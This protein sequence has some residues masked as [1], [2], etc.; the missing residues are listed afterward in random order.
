MPQ[1]PHD[2][3]Y[4]APGPYPPIMVRERNTDYARVIY[5][6]F[7]GRDSELTAITQYLY[8]HFAANNMEVA[9]LLENIAMVEMHHLEMLGQVIV[10]LGGDPRYWGSGLSY[11]NGSYVNYETDLCRALQANLPGEQ[12]AQQTYQN[13]A[14]QIQDPYVRE[15]LLRIAR[16]EEVHERLLREAIDRYCR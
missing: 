7:A 15:I 8:H 4:R 10:L 14:A 3:R 12:V 16:D 13:H 6:D 9:D 11:W 5:D 2:T 1:H